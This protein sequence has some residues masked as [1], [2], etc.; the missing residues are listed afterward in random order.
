QE[1]RYYRIDY[2]PIAL[3]T[4]DSSDGMPDKS[5]S[6][7]NHLLAGSDAPDF[8]PDSEQYRWFEAQLADA[9][10]NSRFTFVQSHHTM[11]GSGPHSIPFGKPNFSEQSGIAMRVIL[12]LL[13]RYG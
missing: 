11:F 2:G 6:D 5:A 9:Q 8:N 4:L 10:R 3:I 12:P 1:G 7:T 13:L